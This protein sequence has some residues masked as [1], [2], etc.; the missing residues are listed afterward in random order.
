ML[1]GTLCATTRAIC[2]ILENYQTEEGIQIPEVL[3]PYMGGKNFIP[4]VFKEMPISKGEKGKKKSENK[5]KK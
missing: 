5:N 3:Q 4:F 1:N 2:A